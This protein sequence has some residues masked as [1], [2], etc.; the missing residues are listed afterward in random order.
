VRGT[1]ELELQHLYRAMEFLEAHR[2][3]LE[4]AIF[5]RVSS[6]LNMEV[7]LVFY[8]TTSLHFEID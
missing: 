7:D 2:D 4:E 6:L 8:D 1:D 3:R 5:F